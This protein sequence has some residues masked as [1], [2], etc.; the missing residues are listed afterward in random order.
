MS[1]S[2]V[3][4]L[5]RITLTCE[6][7]GAFLPCP[8]LLSVVQIRRWSTTTRLP[9]CE[10]GSHRGQDNIRDQIFS[11][12][13]KAIK[14]IYHTTEALA[15][16]VTN[17]LWINPW[18]SCLARRQKT[19]DM[20]NV[21]T[22]CSFTSWLGAKQ[23]SVFSYDILHLIKIIIFDLDQINHKISLLVWVSKINILIFII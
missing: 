3:V 18:D 10:L 9:P 11:K 8:R 6:T 5:W 13:T 17:D 22:G 4:R 20:Q 2:A 7:V 23:V 14:Y 21:L 15:L 12:L 1:W 19:W 16:V